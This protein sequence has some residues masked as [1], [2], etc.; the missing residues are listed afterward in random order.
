M[1]IRA[2]TNT[3]LKVSPKQSSTLEDN[4]MIKIPKGT[5]IEIQ[6]VIEDQGHLC[7]ETYLW[8][9]HVSQ[10]DQIEYSDQDIDIMAR[11]IWGE[12][13]GEDKQGRVAVASVIRNRAIKSPAYNWPNTPKAVCR[14]PWQFS[15]WNSNDPNLPKM[16]ALTDQN[17]I[18]KECL[19]VAESVLSGQ[20]LD[21]TKGADHY[22]AIT[23]NTPS[24]A[25]GKKPTVTIGHHRFYRL[26]N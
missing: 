19:A 23:I 4:Q 6:N 11:T 9:D 12:A 13:R 15:C 20:E 3:I 10:D 26:I 22:Y 24:W 14:Q 7:F 16:Q 1:K 21:I 17:S 18:F 8:A 5:E 2:K 25:I